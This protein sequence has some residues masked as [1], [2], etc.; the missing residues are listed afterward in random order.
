MPNAC[1]SQE[2]QCINDLKM[3][4]KR[5]VHSFATQHPPDTLDGEIAMPDVTGVDSCMLARYPTEETDM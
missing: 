3:E 5:P 2:L 4:V 1:L